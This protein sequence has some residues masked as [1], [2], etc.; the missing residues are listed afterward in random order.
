[1]T[2]IA[3]S[4]C[5]ELGISTNEIF[6]CMCRKSIYTVC[7]NF[8]QY[9]GVALVFSCDQSA[10]R[11]LLSVCPSVRP[12]VCLSVCL[13]VRP[14]SS[15]TFCVGS[16][17][18][19]ETAIQWVCGTGS[20]WVA[21]TLQ[22]S[23][24]VHSTLSNMILS[25]QKNFHLFSSQYICVILQDVRLLHL[26]HNVP[27]IIS[28]LNFQELLPMTE[29]MSMQ[30]VIFRGQRSRLQRSKPHLAVSGP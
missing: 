18:Q 26:L 7:P 21:L 16:C 2:D 25:K 3:I 27:V 17:Y 23:Q 11:T 13:S 30:K 5:A 12:P 14:F 9:A 28:S 15:L 22:Y 20:W 8:V 4:S 1:M 10:L 24:L 19:T 29:V 6:F